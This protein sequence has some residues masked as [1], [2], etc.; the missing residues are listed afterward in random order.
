MSYWCVIGKNGTLGEGL[1]VKKE[2]ILEAR[3][4]VRY[5]AVNIGKEFI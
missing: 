1:D 3:A 5:E 4:S 2:E